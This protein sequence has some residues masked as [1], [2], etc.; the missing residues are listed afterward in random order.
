GDDTCLVA[1]RVAEEVHLE[2]R[3]CV[4]G[5]DDKVADS[6]APAQN[7]CRSRHAP[8]TAPTLPPAVAGWP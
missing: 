3:T 5:Y 7:C 2:E 6:T 8:S 1:Q 4:P